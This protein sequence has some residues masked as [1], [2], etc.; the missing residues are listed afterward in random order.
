MHTYILFIMLLAANGDALSIST[1][2][3]WHSM[4]ECLDAGSSLQVA[5]S[6]GGSRR[7]NLEVWCG[8]GPDDK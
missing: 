4:K 7:R 3:G 8:P 2:P 1:V 6:L 5:A